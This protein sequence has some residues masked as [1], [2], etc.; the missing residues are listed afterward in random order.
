MASQFLIRKAFFS[1]EITQITL[2]RPSG[3]LRGTLLLRE[4]LNLTTNTAL[5]PL[6]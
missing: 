1:L 6:L 5:A 4:V 3:I 2:D